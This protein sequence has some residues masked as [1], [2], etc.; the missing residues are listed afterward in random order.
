MPCTVMHCV[1]IRNFEIKCGIK[2][3]KVFERNLKG[4]NELKDDLLMLSE[5]SREWSTELNLMK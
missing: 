4:S 2:H 5:W 3:A 1:K